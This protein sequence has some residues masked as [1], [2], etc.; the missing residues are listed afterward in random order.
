MALDYSS[1]AAPATTQKGELEKPGE[2]SERKPLTKRVTGGVKV[3]EKSP[4]QKVAGGFFEEDLAN[5]K[6]YVVKDVVVPLIKD[7]IADA[8][9]GAI[10]ML[11][12]GSST[13]RH[14]RRGRNGYRP[15]QVQQAGYTAYNQFSNG[16]STARPSRTRTTQQQAYDY[17][18]LIF[19][20]RGDAEGVLADL[21]LALQQYGVAT[22]ADLYDLVGQ[23]GAFTDQKYGW[24]N[25]DEA[26][27]KRV[28]EGYLIVLPRALSIV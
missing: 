14:G 25:L 20:D 9:I 21:R 11:L 8:F 15:G 2:K 3:K 5:V 24:K 18:E 4:L 7:A 10:E 27:V 23:T 28:R 12:Y 13:G 16:A 6:D 1:L 22:V 26:H 17:T 19:N